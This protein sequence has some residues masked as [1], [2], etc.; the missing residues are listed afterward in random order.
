M[1]EN[2]SKKEI[3]NV[4][5]AFSNPRS[6]FVY[7]I[8]PT[9]TAH[10]WGEVN[11]IMIKR[12]P[13]IQN[14]ISWLKSIDLDLEVSNNSKMSKD[15]FKDNL[16]GNGI[17]N[18]EENVSPVNQEPILM[19]IRRYLTD[20]MTKYKWYKLGDE[21]KILTLPPGVLA[22]HYPKKSSTGKQ[23]SLIEQTFEYKRLGDKF[24]MC[25]RKEFLKKINWQKYITTKKDKNI[26]NR[27]KGC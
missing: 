12:I 8:N 14:A 20:H 11:H 1:E 10:Y 19:T 13:K 5:L 16:N 7:E 22:K 26:F 18:I 3:I 21:N 24:D 27:K 6:D 9:A 25:S 17:D 2:S 15:P 23:L 4:N